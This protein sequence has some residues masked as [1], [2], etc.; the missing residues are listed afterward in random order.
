MRKHIIIV[1]ARTIAY[2]VS[3]SKDEVLAAQIKTLGDS[4]LVVVVVETI[5]EHVV[6][7]V[8]SNNNNNDNYR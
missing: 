5:D 4:S 8:C 3:T 2:I 6:Y 7:V 1:T